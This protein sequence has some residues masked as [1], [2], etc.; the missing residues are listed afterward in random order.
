MVTIVE[1]QELEEQPITT[2]GQTLP[3]TQ[4]GQWTEL[5]QFG[6]ISQ[7]ATIPFWT[8][9]AGG[10]AGLLGAQFV[11]SYIVDNYLSGTDPLDPTKPLYG[12]EIIQ[13][14]KAGTKLGMSIL[15]SVINGFVPFGGIFDA[16]AKG[17]AIAI[18]AEPVNRY[19]IP[20][21]GYEPVKLRRGNPAA[22]NPQQV[23]L[24]PSG[25]QRAPS[26]SPG[27]AAAQAARAGQ[28]L[29]GFDGGASASVAGTNIPPPGLGIGF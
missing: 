18:I 7:V 8:Q 5:A 15:F 23:I 21:A 1:K 17:A 27:L 28:G 24:T 10:A 26:S 16:A 13:L 29:V 20:Y 2:L 14:V 9:A 3:Q 11:A 19:L 25:P 22:S 4:E 6:A 12:E